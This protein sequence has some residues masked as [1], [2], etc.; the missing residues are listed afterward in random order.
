M[1]SKRMK[2]TDNMVSI[3]SD[4]GG[5]EANNA[6]ANVFV[7]AGQKEKKKKK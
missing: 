5:L 1:K 7:V 4:D 6:N 2:T 3:I